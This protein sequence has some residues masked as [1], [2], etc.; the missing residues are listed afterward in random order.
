MCGK[1]T[2]FR[3]KIMKRNTKRLAAALIVLML[4]AAQTVS[5]ANTQGTGAG[6]TAIRKVSKISISEKKIAVDVGFYIKGSPGSRLSVSQIR[7]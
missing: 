4:L 2:V 6:R 1:E 3:G 7:K 5:G